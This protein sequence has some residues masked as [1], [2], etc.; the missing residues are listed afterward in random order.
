L[1]VG[2]ASGPE[3]DQVAAVSVEARI[4][5]RVSVPSM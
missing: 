2:T 1:Y 3:I 5:G 4:V